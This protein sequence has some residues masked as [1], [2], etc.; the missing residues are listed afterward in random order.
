MSLETTQMP[1]MLFKIQVFISTRQQD[2]V[3]YLNIDQPVTALCRH[4]SDDDDI[5][6]LGTDSH[7]IIYDT[8]E[9]AIK[10]NKEVQN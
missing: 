7:L 5:I 10:W 4:P 8:K 9:N 2:Q 6:A 3:Q 1:T